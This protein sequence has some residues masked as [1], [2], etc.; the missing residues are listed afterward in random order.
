M[1]PEETATPYV[2][3]SRLTEARQRHHHRCRTATKPSD[4][5]D[6]RRELMQTIREIAHVG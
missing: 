3:D 6:A 4:F 5:D 1:I 2:E